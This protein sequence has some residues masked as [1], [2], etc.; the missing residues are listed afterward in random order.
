MCTRTTTSQHLLIPNYSIS[1]FPMGQQIIEKKILKVAKSF[2]ANKK[3]DRSRLNMENGVRLYY[4]Y[5]KVNFFFVISKW[6]DVSLWEFSLS[7]YTE[8][9]QKN[10]NVKPMDMYP[11][12]MNNQPH[13]MRF[14]WICG[15]PLSTRTTF[16]CFFCISF[17]WTNVNRIFIE[18]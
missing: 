15:N 18:S 17:R 10:N 11:K 13:P 3:L 5:L 4:I 16:I 2:E 9:T 1:D 6:P 14:R 7:G 8:L 12:R